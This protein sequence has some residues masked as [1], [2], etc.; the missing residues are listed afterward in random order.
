MTV[1]ET[2]FLLPGLMCDS[3]VWEHQRANLPDHARIIVP[4]F[5]GFDSLTAMAEHVLSS[6]PDR[7]AVAGH[8]MGGR[9]A[10]ELFNLAPDRVTRLALLDTGVHPKAAGEEEIRQVYID[11]AKQ[12]GMQ[13]VASKWIAPM[14]HPDRISDRDLIGRITAMVERT[15]VEEFIGQVQAL[16]NRPDASPYLQRIQC[17][18]LLLAGRHDTWSPPDQHEAMLKMIGHARL[19]IIEHAGHMAPM[20]KPEAVTNALR[21]WLIRS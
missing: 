15:T 19:I 14:V 11:L 9:V 20:E 4:D 1:A 12:G 8:S 7:Y 2:L 10:L 18:T 3:A 17:P 21:E 13:A 6:A 5:R 16:L